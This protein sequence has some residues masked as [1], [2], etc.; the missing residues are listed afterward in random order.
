MNGATVRETLLFQVGWR[1]RLRAS[2]QDVQL[3]KN[4]QRKKKDA[5]FIVFASLRECSDTHHLILMHLK[6]THT[7]RRTKCVHTEIFTVGWM[8]V[9]KKN[10]KIH[11]GGVT[12]T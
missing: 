2:S 12:S 3:E 10:N 7:L 8:K 1:M 9:Y 11:R 4:G 6:H 5:K